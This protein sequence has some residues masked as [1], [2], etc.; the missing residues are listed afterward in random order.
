MKKLVCTGLAAML[1]GCASSIL[2]DANRAS[3]NPSS[4]TMQTTSKTYGLTIIGYNYTDYGFYSY[5]VGRRGGRNL[6]P[7][8]PTTGGSKNTCCF[9]LFT[10]MSESRKVKVKW[11][12]GIRKGIWCEME[13]PLK[14]HLPAKPEY[15]E[16]HFY[17]DGHIELAVTEEPSPPRLKL[18]RF[19]N[20]PRHAEGNVV[21]DDKFALCKHGY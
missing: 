13:V 14:G 21:N 9:S 15:I 4:M 20:G 10:P 5:E 18:D 2:A 6:V 1:S 11:S 12:R 8:T 19:S 7:S 3:S 16:V 17:Q